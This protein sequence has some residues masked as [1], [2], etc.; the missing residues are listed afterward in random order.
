MSGVSSR[1]RKSLALV[2]G[3]VAIVLGSVMVPTP[4]GAEIDSVTVV[5]SPN[6]GTTVNVLDSVSCVSESWCV[7]VGN[8]RDV[9]VRQTLV[10]LWDGSSWSVVPSPNVGD[11]SNSLLSV[12]CLSPSSCIAVGHASVDSVRQTLALKWDGSSWSVVPSPNIGDEDNQLSSVSCV[13]SSFCIAVGRAS[14]DS[15][16]QTLVQVWDGSSWSVVSSPSSSG[17]DNQLD[18]VSCV[19]TSSCVAVGDTFDGSVSATLSQVW[20]GTSWSVVPS[21]NPSDSFS[22]LNAVSC[23]S[24]SWCTAVGGFVGEGGILRTEALVWD[25]S[26][27]SVMP[28]PSLSS[29][30]HRLNSVSCASSSS[31]VAVGEFAQT[32]DEDVA[33]VMVWDGS[34]WSVLPSPNPSPGASSFPEG[35]WCASTATC[36]AVGYS[37]DGVFAGTLVMSLTGP[38]PMPVPD[39]IDPIAPAFTG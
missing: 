37:Y 35:V 5:P 28:S 32:E 23:V 25:G 30:D 2:V 38:E 11:G 3:T 15:V 12:S 36:T 21:P 10:L 19:S 34:S 24:S 9:L 14:V 1:I 13:S 8:S 22:T 26:S 27:W 18:S 31:C 17:V 20:D 4:V 39:P 29:G 33:L 6:R 7:A 16:R